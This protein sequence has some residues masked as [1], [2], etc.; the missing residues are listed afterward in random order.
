[1]D[2]AA[3]RALE[4][5]SLVHDADDEPARGVGTLYDHLNKCRSDAGR[6]LLRTWMRRPL[7]DLRRINER[8]DVVEALIESHVI[9]ST[10]SDSLLRQVPDISSIERRLLQDKGNLQDCYRLYRLVN[11]MKRVSFPTF[12]NHPCLV[13]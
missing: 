1:M 5:F 12:C 13:F 4:L 3:V 9:R 10:L 8:L 2:A 6:K 11:L 7:S